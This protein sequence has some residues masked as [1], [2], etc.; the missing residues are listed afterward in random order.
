LYILREEKGK[1][2]KQKDRRVQSTEAETSGSPMKANEENLR[3]T[4]RAKRFP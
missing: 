2:N 3:H 1:R 4:R